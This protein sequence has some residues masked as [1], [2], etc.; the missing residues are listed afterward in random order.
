VAQAQLRPQLD[1]LHVKEA[2]ADA[3]SWIADVR[4]WSLVHHSHRIEPGC[5][6]FSGLR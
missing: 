6:N 3:Q 2:I 5:V 4:P 1:A